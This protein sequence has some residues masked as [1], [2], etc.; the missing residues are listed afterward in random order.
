M[1]LGFGHPFEAARMRFGGIA[2]HHDH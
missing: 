1:R 2:A